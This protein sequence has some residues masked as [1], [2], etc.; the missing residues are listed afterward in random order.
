MNTPPA[1][2]FMYHAWASLLLWLL[3]VI[4]PAQTYAQ[5]YQLAELN[6]EQIRALDHERTVVLLPGGILEE[7]GPYLPYFADG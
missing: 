4:L 7:H 2:L 5:V 3:I 6:T 1:R